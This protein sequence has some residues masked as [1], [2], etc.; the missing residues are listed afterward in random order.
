MTRRSIGSTSSGD[1]SCFSY[2][3]P[4]STFVYK[5]ENDGVVSFNQGQ[6]SFRY[7]HGPCPSPPPPRPSPPPP[8][9]SPLID[10]SVFVSIAIGVSVFVSV[11]GVAILGFACWRRKR[12]RMTER[13]G[14]L[15]SAPTY[16]MGLN[17]AFISA[18]QPSSQPPV[19]A[20][21]NK[22]PAMTPN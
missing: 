22:M 11:L 18:A 19:V 21:K 2:P 14:Q 8:S 20:V 1:S 3:A 10:V 6:I 5:V 17:E 13:G 7:L 9:A 16:D 4:E 15:I 12:A